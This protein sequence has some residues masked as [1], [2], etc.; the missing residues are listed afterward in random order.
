MVETVLITGA[1]GEI[2]HG[3]ITT[4]GSTSAV[5]IIAIDLHPIDEQIRPFCSETHIGDI[6]DPA[7]FHQWMN[8]PVHTIFHLAA[9][10]S[11]KAEWNPELAH[12]VNV[13]GT[14]NV[15]RFAYENS[16][17][18]GH[19]VKVLFPSSIAVYGIPNKETKQQLPPIRE[20]EWTAPITIYG[21]NKLYCELLGRYYEKYYKL[22]DPQRIESPI[23]FRALR[24]PG[25]ISAFTQPTGG[26]SDYAPAML[27]AAA[28]GEAYRCFVREDTVIPFMIMPDAIQALLDLAAAPKEQLTYWV[29]NVQAF[30]FSAY[31]F[32]EKLRH[33]FPNFQ[34]H[35][36]PDLRRQQIV[37]S[38]PREIDDRRARQD[39]NWSPKYTLESAFEEYLIP[40]VTKLYLEQ[41]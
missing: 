11:T 20:E 31:Q 30:S 10:L 39:W 22:L 40:N 6:T 41:S 19:S 13:D 14:I 9:I 26:T 17:R 2:G 27:H 18:F 33:Y 15:L 29:Y 36:H 1:N 16:I 12:R 5:S 21:I 7:V 4:L 28:K 34:I 3:L 25:I 32:A 8:Q 24:F 37:D 38:W 23:D 35:F